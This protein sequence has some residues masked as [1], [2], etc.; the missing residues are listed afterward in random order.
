[1]RHQRPRRVI[2]PRTETL[3]LR[4]LGPIRGLKISRFPKSGLLKPQGNLVVQL[5]GNR[6][7]PTL[8]LINLANLSAEF[9]LL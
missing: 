7:L 2:C 4:E 1:M 3:A 6:H 5:G 8:A 9:R